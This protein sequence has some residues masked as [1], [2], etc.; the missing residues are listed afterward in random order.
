MAIL[1]TAHL[2][3]PSFLTISHLFTPSFLTTS[4]LF[5]P[6]SACKDTTFFELCKYF[7]KKS[8]HE[9]HFF[10]NLPI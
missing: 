7:D 8:A 1:A 3:T 2:F 9:E 4:H 6:S 5:T 10:E